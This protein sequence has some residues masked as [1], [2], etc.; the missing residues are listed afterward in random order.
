MSINNKELTKISHLCK[1]SI[2]DQQKEQLII[3]INKI[4]NW[5]EILNEVDTKNIEPL[6]NVHQKNITT[7]KDKISDGDLIDS[8][9]K[10]TPHD[11]YN[12]F[13]VPKVIE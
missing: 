10:N 3:N 12:Y 1:I 4:I 13:T 11:K 7:A 6:I 5:M 8:I 2:P 9:F